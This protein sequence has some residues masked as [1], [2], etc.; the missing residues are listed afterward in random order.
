VKWGALGDDGGGMV[1]E[2]KNSFIPPFS[3]PYF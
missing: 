2:Y 3:P 1:G